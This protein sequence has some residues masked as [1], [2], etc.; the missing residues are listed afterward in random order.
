MKEP[1]NLTTAE[2]VEANQLFE[3][4]IEQGT[5][6][7]G[8]QASMTQ[9]I[10]NCK[11]RAIG[12]SGWGYETMNPNCDIGLLDATLLAHYAASTFVESKPRTIKY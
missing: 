9:T 7:H 4:A 2:Y 3:N 8:E 10:S 5:I 11:K 6:C 12:T 1:Q